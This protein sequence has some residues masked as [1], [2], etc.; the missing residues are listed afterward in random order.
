V[1]YKHRIGEKGIIL[2]TGKLFKIEIPIKR[3]C[4][5]GVVKINNRAHD[6]TAN[7]HEGKLHG[8]YTDKGAK[9][10]EDDIAVSYKYGVLQYMTI[11]MQ[12]AYDV[13]RI[14]E[15]KIVV[16]SKSESRNNYI[17]AAFNAKKDELKIIKYEDIVDNESEVMIGW[18]EDLGKHYNQ[19][20]L[21][22]AKESTMIKLVLNKDT[23]NCIN[24]SNYVKENFEEYAGI[25]IDTGFLCDSLKDNLQLYLTK[26][27]I[28]MFNNISAD[29]LLSEECFLF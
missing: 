2:I 24:F 28:Y 10:S 15:N 20:T 25:K 6:I 26:H 13:L 21:K 29:D 17:E 18:Y 11:N 3:N 8:M 1:L 9:G 16:S 27:L 7:F 19:C 12:Y 4:I 23:S 5:H 14:N 22:D